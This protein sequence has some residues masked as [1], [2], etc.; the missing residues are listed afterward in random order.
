M[1]NGWFVMEPSEQVRAERS[2]VVRYL[3]R[4][5]DAERRHANAMR[6]DAGTQA[7]VEARWIDRIAEALESAADDIERVRHWR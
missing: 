1:S 3:R 5:A 6:A 7:E 2:F 4:C